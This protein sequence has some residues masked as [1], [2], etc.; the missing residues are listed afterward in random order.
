[1]NRSTHGDMAS[2][3]TS[4]NLEGCLPN[5]ETGLVQIRPYCPQPWTGC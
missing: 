1:M 5:D 4:N 2:S 3:G